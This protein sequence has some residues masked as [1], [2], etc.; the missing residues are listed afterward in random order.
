[1]QRVDEKIWQITPPTWRFDLSLKV[2]LIE[3]LA[4]IYGYQ[5]IPTSLPY[6]HLQF[7]AQSETHISLS[8]LQKLLID[9]GYHEAI[10][11][12]FTSAKLQ[13]II[14]PSALSLSLVNPISSEL[15]VMRTSLWPGL[16]NALLYNQQRQQLSC[17]LFETGLCFQ[18]KEG[19]LEQQDYLAGV[20]SGHSVPEQ[21]G[22]ATT[23]LD[24]F[25]VKSDLEA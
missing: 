11:Y 5:H 10:N 25:T 8:R 20:A 22:L 2:D 3:E 14:T 13:N 18:M 19:K 1:V 12:S 15:S 4:R 23:P 16:L 6:N 24:F 17:R 7:L 9:R 21:W